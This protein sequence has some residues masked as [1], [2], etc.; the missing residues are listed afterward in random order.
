MEKMISLEDLILE[1]REK[2]TL[3]HLEMEDGPN[4]VLF[5]IFFQ[6]V[7]SIVVDYPTYRKFIPS[8]L[9]LLE[10]NR[11]TSI[12]ILINTFLIQFERL[13]KKKQ[14]DESDA[15]I[16]HAEYGDDVVKRTLSSVK[17]KFKEGALIQISN[18]DFDKSGL[19]ESDKKGF[20]SFIVDFIQNSAETIVWDKE[21]VY[22]VMLQLALARNLLNDQNDRD[23]F[24]ILSAMA[25]DRFSTS[26]L[27]QL[28]RDVCEEFI[29][30]SYKD[31]KEHWG[32]SN[33]FRCYSNNSS[34]VPALLYANLSLFC[35]LKPKSAVSSKYVKDIIWQA[36]KSLE[37]FPFLIWLRRFMNPSPLT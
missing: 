36:I 10:E 12:N 11:T 22:N 18:F 33:S 19:S 15:S 24:Y 32:Y 29:L 2:I 26:G 6:I 23:T 30:S 20:L 17:E 34:A 37:T 4:E 28:A 35:A 27:H 5:S 7:E 8:L 13:L 9:D 14:L 25:I 16:L 31:G 21:R 3:L 1:L